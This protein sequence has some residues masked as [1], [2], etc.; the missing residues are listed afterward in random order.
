MLYNQSLFSRCIIFN[1]FFFFI[2][3]ISLNYRLLFGRYV[4]PY[5]LYLNALQ[6]PQ[7]FSKSED[8]SSYPSDSSDGDSDSTTN[9]KNTKYW[10]FFWC[11]LLVKDFIESSIES[12]YRGFLMMTDY[13]VIIAVSW[14]SINI[15]IYKRGFLLFN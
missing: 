12:Y 15:E 8:D 11:W 1:K 7:D 4:V 2:R 14:F 13:S 9:K 6:P 10:S 3:C 5:L